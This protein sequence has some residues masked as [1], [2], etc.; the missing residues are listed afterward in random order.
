MIHTDTHK[1]KEKNKSNGKE[2]KQKYK[3]I[4]DQ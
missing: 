4:P 3:N 1:C 2:N